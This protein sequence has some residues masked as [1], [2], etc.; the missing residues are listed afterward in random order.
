MFTY[1]ISNH[2][3]L[4]LPTIPNYTTH[5][6][7]SSNFLMKLDTSRL[8][9]TLVEL[10]CNNNDLCYIGDL[11]KFTQLKVV[12]VNNNNLEYLPKMPQSLEIL[13]C[14]NNKIK[15]LIDIKEMSLIHLDCSNNNLKMIP[16]L[17]ISLIHYKAN[18]NLLDDELC[19]KEN[20]NNY[21][22]YT[23]YLAF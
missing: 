19:D 11:S 10:I 8:P 12:N 21:W 9:L 23:K 14:N 7:I 3:L 15:H 4:E 5:L 22:Q 13:W 2:E 1:N 20:V 17:P 16:E 18:N 6:D